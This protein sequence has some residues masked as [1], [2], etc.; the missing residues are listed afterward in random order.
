MLDHVAK[1]DEAEV[2]NA[3]K[4]V[5]YA[6]TTEVDGLEAERLDD[7]GGQRVPAARH[8]QATA[9]VEF[10]AQKRAG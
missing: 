8:K 4:A 1:V 2:G 10:G 6:G 9:L 5:R 3:V 7:T